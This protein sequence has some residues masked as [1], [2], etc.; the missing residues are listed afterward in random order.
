MKRL[1]A[2]FIAW[3]VLGLGIA[4]AVPA[5]PLYEPPDPPKP[6][7]T[8][9]LDETTWLGRLYADNEQV[10]FHANGT[11]TYG[12]GKGGMTS[13]GVWR[14]TGNQLYFEINKWSEYQTTVDGDVIQGNGWNKNGQKCQPLLKRVLNEKMQEKAKW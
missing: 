2:C 3:F 10:T 4:Q 12:Y 7:P 8:F 5:R 13:P 6:P 14:L 1:F 9:S 11:L